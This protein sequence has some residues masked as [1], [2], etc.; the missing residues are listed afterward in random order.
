[1][2]IDGFLIGAAVLSPFMMAPLLYIIGA[3]NPI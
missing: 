3:I 2:V 1:M